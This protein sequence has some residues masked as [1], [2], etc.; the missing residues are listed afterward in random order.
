MTGETILKSEDLYASFKAAVNKLEDSKDALEGA[1]DMDDDHDFKPIALKMSNK[2]V[3]EDQ[4]IHD[5]ILERNQ[6]HLDDNL[7]AYQE[8]AASLA[9]AADVELDFFYD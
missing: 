4:D 8:E 5:K 2:H 1:R 7:G 9:I 6:R 3:M